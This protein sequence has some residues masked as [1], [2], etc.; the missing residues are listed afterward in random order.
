MPIFP[1][2][3]LFIALYVLGTPDSYRSVTAKFDVG[4][5]TAW[6][7]VHHIVSAICKYRNYFIRWPSQNEAIA[8]F[9]RIEARYGFPKVIGA[10]DG[11]HIQIPAPKRDAQSYI[12]RKSVHSMQLQVSL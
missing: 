1:E 2:K 3:Q 7:A 9:N 10:V 8:T 5:A 4:N 12:N 6:R 11:T